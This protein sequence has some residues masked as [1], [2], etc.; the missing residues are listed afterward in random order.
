MIYKVISTGSDGNAV[1][2]N[3]D[4][5]IDCGVPY[6]MVEP[7]I[8]DIKLGL[9]TH[10][11]GDHFRP[12][13]VAMLA[14]MRPSLRWCAP[15]WMAQPLIDAGV[16]RGCIDVIKPGPQGRLVYCIGDKAVVVAAEELQ[17]NVPNVGYKLRIGDE[18]VFYATD[19]GTLDG[20]SAKNYDMYLI[21]ANHT[22]ME[23]TQ[24]LMEKLQAG[25]YAYEYK[26][27]ENHLSKEQ[28]TDW[29]L[30]NVGPNS[31]Y[32]F[33]HQHKGGLEDGCNIQDDI[34]DL[35]D[36]QQGG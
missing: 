2:L 19:T 36:G 4:M 13:T 9:L 23:I 27:A 17:H 10:I 14:R 8:R 35:L 3:G 18:W 34:P 1:L 22:Q 29:L 11:H 5:L 30:E 28:A 15:A 7:Y 21:E 6:K 20:I 12:S 31:E 32:Q 25:E 24:R 26:A 33:L 16:M